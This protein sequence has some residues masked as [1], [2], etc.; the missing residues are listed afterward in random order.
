MHDEEHGWRFADYEL[1]E[2]PEWMAE[3][4]GRACSNT[5]RSLPFLCECTTQIGSGLSVPACMCC[6]RHLTA[7]ES[8]DGEYKSTTA[9]STRCRPSKRSLNHVG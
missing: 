1:I 5:W 9:P 7:L 8:H 2:Y 6:P 4:R 3:V